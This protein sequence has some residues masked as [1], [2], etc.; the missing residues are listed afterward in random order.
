MF[1]KEVFEALNTN[2]V[3]YLVEGGVALNLHG[4]PRMTYD[5]DLMISLESE[6][7]HKLWRVLEQQEFRPRIPIKEA[8]LLDDRKRE[9]L[10]T[11]KNMLVASFYK[12]QKELL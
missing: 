9:F 7:I 11:T 5:L 8:D 2:Q 12:G 4:Y 1:Y 6:N 3:Q 10:K